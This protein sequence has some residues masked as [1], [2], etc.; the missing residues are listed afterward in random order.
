MKY[1]VCGRIDKL[2]IL[3]KHKYDY[4]ELNFSDMV[5][6]DEAQFGETYDAI[7]HYGLPAECYNCF[8]KSDIK[9]NGD[10]DYDFIASY[11]EKGFSRAK[12][13]GGKIAVLGSGAARRIPD[14]Y[15]RENAVKQFVRVLNIC[16]EIAG[17]HGMTLAVEPLNIHETNFINTVAEGIEICK[18]ADNE[19]VKCLVD[20]FHV[21]M[22][23]ETTDAVK[24]SAGMLCHAH[25]ARPNPDRRAPSMADI[26]ECSAW[27]EA[28]KACGYTARISLE[29]KFSPDFEQEVLEARRVLDV[30]A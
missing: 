26:S 14:G 3:K 17:K 30:F 29:A 10:I 9:L 7:E 21:Y 8:F 19:N 23:G 13:L 25:I 1:G 4:I 2:P 6:S 20:F 15:Q 18:L 16:G 27:A 12:T 5:F 28:L 11:A 22:N 24:N